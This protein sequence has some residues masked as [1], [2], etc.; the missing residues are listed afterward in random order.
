VKNLFYFLKNLS[1]QNLFVYC[2]LSLSFLP[3]YSC[4]IT[5]PPI[6]DSNPGRRDYTWTVDTLDTPS[7]FRMWANSP[8]DV[9][10]TSAGD[11]DKS[12]AHFD[13]IKWSSYGVSGLFNLS[14]IYGFSSDNIFIGADNGSIWRFDGTNW[15]L[16]AQLTKDGHSD[17]VFDN[18]WGSSPNDFFAF[19]AYPDE[20]GNASNAVIAHYSNNKWEILNSDKLFGIAEHLYKNIYDQKIYL[21]VIGGRNN[22]DST[23][24]YEYSQGRYYKLYSNIWLQGLQADISLIQGEVYFIMGSQIA[25]RRN[26]QFQTILNVD[27]ENFYQRIWGRN[28]KDIF[29]MMIDG[30]AHYNGTDIEYLFLYKERTQI[31]GAALFENDVFFLIYES[32]TNLNLVYHGTL[33]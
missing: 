32:Q 3:L 18:I 25:V 4:N 30:L 10:C 22:I 17:I 28:N 21:Q 1:A 2:I 8:T 15:N 9:W 16:F 5:E 24:I 19:G 27:Y 7:Y 26:N 23:H 20:S 31:Y 13:G 14:S 6:D 33:K 12:I 11:W 29:L